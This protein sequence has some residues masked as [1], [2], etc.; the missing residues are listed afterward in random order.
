MTAVTRI[1]SPI[2]VP[3]RRRTDARRPAVVAGW[4]M[5]GAVAAFLT[6]DAVIHLLTVPAARESSLRLGFDPR[7][8]LFMGAAEV[9]FL[10]LYLYRRTLVLGA[11]LLSTYLGGAF[12]A[13]LR[14]DAPLFSTLLFPVYTALFVWGGLWLRDRSVRAVVPLRRG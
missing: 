1:A 7:L 12:A 6:F 11:V 4:V 2:D 3:A 8:S 9:V 5:T 10:A 13:Q 14:V